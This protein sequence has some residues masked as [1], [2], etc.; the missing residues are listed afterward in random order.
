AD[1]RTPGATRASVIAFPLTCRGGRVGGIIG[2]DRETSTTAPVFDAEVER[3]I[4][5]LL[6]PAAFA[7]DNAQLIK[8]VE[9]PWVTDDLTRL[10]N[11][12]YLNQ[13]LRRETKRAL[14]ARRPLSLLF[15]DLDNFKSINNSYGHLFG[16]RALVETASV[17]RGSARETDI[18]ARY[19]GDEFVMVLPDTD[20]E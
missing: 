4:G 19:G 13:A 2:L 16:S 15:L 8:R 9:A 6:E 20:R 3:A 12:R 17:I 10:Y 1:E 5:E 14:R 7:L 18:V 11:L